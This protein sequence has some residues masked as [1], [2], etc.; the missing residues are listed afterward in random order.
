MT[1]VRDE[2]FGEISVKKHPRARHIRIS[3]AP[4]GK[5]RA[6][7]P[8]HA[9]LRNLKSMLSTSR[10]EIRTMLATHGPATHYASGMQIGKSHS[11]ITQHGPSLLV[12]RQQLKL[13][14]TLPPDT[15]MDDVAVQDKVRVEVRK[16]LRKE[17]SHYLPRR[18]NVLADKLGCEYE[19]VRF[20]HA[21]TRW[22]S[23]SST[24]TISLNI[25]LMN[26]PFALI[27]YVLI[28]EL[29]HTR[30]MNHSP[31]FWELV[32]SADPD[33]LMH[34]KALKQHTPTI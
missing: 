24:G 26:L 25:A 31:F 3:I 20:S 30:Q 12:R 19:R 33:Y 14:V 10:D 23:C 6:S 18:L 11:L 27:D 9:S 8:S 17:A 22:G 16:I 32:R 29:C 13:V 7:M 2:E 1:T 5:L 15:P 4:N 21:S 28:H 34:R